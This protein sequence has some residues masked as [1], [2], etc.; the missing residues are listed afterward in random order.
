MSFISDEE[1]CKLPLLERIKYLKE[2]PG[3]EYGKR[4]PKPDWISDDIKAMVDSEGK[5]LSRE[6]QCK[7]QV[8]RDSDFL[9]LNKLSEDV[10]AKV[11][12]IFLDCLGKGFSKSKVKQELY[13]NLFMDFYDFVDY[14]Y[15]CADSIASIKDAVFNSKKGKNYFKRFE[16]KDCCSKCKR[17]DDKI[18]LWS[19]IPLD[20]NKTNDKYADYVI[21]DDRNS[22]KKSKIPLTK[23]C[24]YCRGGWIQWFPEVDEETE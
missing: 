23:C 17:L 19:D 16:M 5:P 18:A 24:K 21:W 8:I 1:F 9:T 2:H 15:D 14:E 6:R 10:K 12:D 13:D 7:I 4:E 22:E 3:Y 11:K 20:S